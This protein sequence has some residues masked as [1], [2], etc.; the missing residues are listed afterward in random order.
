MEVDSETVLLSF[1]VRDYVI[2]IY[3]DLSTRCPLTAEN[4]DITS[5]LQLY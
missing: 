1:A 4:S 2:G 5:D 3:A